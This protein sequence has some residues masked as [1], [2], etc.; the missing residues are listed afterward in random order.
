M[1]PANLLVSSREV[2][3]KSRSQQSRWR[4]LA[5]FWLREDVTGAGSVGWICCA[6]SDAQS[7]AAACLVDCVWF[8]GAT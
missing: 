5:I 3:E 8:H 2:R 1:T 4:R 7:W 6:G